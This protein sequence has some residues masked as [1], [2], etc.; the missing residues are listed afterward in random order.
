MNLVKTIFIFSCFI[1]YAGDVWCNVF[2]RQLKMDG[3]RF[4]INNFYHYQTATFN[5]DGETE[6]IDADN[7]FYF[8]DSSLVAFW[9][10]T[11]SITLLGGG[12]IR[13]VA[14]ESSSESITNTNL[15]HF[16][17]G[18]RI[19]FKDLL[20]MMGN[21]EIRFKQKAYTNN[22]FGAGLSPS[23]DLVLGNDGIFYHLGLNLTKQLGE[24]HLIQLK[25]AYVITPSYLS[26]Q[27]DYDVQY[28]F[29]G[30]NF[31]LGFGLLGIFSLKNH[32]FSENPNQ[33]PSVSRGVTKYFNGVNQQ[34][35]SP[36]A[37]LGFRV[38][39]LD[40]TTKA[41]KTLSGV[42]TDEAFRFYVNLA[43]DFDGVDTS[44][45]RDSIFKE[46]TNSAK[47]IQVAPRGNFFKINQGLSTSVE[48]GMS[49][50]IYQSDFFGGNVLVG[51]GVVFS[52]ETDSSVV[53]VIKFYQKIPIKEGFIVRFK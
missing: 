48:K 22:F 9:G 23:D 1:I 50:D 24:S 2:G 44:V 5:E 27:L 17:L 39:G 18:A 11:E 19:Q 25:S 7:N 29:Q 42:D 40:V 28:L 21:F 47:I 41:S 33:R 32:P 12:G 20:S 34:E 4:E 26:D 30:S 8:I 10:L 6:T 49:V 15:E 43:L 53:K 14:S 31:N 36:Y 52:S 13:Y 51:S 3:L 38:G 35:L 45:D 16:M 46:Y 37:Q